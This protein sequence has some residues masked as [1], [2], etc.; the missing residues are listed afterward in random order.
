MGRRNPKPGDRVMLRDIPGHPVGTV[1]L[2]DKDKH[3][4][5]ELK[6]GPTFP[7]A[8]TG[9]LAHDAEPPAPVV[10]EPHPGLAADPGDITPSR[11]P[12][13]KPRSR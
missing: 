11:P 8:F 7:V 12:G 1:R 4:H 10:L 6:N 3:A 13:R 9:L 5:V 2:V